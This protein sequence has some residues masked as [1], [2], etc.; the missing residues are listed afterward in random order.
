MKKTYFVPEMNVVKIQAAGM[1]AQSSFDL[2]NSEETV[3]GDK[4]L[5]RRRGTR[6]DYDDNDDDEGYNTIFSTD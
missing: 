3:G 4:A 6:F 2:M 5:S 1:L